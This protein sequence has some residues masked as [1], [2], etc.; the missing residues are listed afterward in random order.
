MRNLVIWF[1]ISIVIV[2]GGY[3]FVTELPFVFNEQSMMPQEDSFIVHPISH[4][5]AV[6]E[7]GDVVAYTDPVGEP[8]AFGKYSSPQLILL[9]DI[10]GDHLNIR[11]LEA[12]SKEDTVLILPQAVAD[13]LS[14]SVLGTR[15]V[16]ANGE[17]TTQ[18]GITIEAIPMYNLPEAE[19]AFHVKGRGN[20]YV[21]EYDDTRVYI[22][23]DTEDIPEMRAL[24]GVD[25]ALICMNLP[26]TMDINAAADAVAAFQPKK[27][28]PYHYRGKE[29]LSDVEQFKSLVEESTEDVEVVLLDW[30]PEQ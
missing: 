30:Y 28:Y 12:L 23:G 17:R 20:G 7:L 25:Y 29:G 13:E 21:L 16:L 11:T 15:V 3:I 26:Y 14:E 27:V 19:D 22:S 1:G 10:H 18:L 9:T 8:A 6:L 5:T 2:I 4:A 24:E